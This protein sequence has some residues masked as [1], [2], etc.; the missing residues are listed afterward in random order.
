MFESF[1]VGARI[2][3]HVFERMRLETGEINRCAYCASVR[4]QRV[5]DEVGSKEDA[6]FGEVEGDDF[7]ERERLAVALAEQMTDD[8]NYL[9]DAHI[10]ELHEELVELVFAASTFN[11]GNKFTITMTLDAEEGSQYQT[12]L[13]YPH[14]EPADVEAPEADD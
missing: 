4:S 14:S 9:T 7:S 11:R 1:F 10:D 5:R 12:G 2:E 3:P 8:P 13:E 6:L